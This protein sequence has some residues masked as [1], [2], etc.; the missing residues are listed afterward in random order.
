MSSWIHLWLARESTMLSLTHIVGQLS[1]L[2]L[3]L[4]KCCLHVIEFLVIN[5]CLAHDCSKHLLDILCWVV[6]RLSWSLK[7]S[8]PQVGWLIRCCRCILTTLRVAPLKSWMLALILIV[9]L[10]R[11][12]PSCIHVIGLL[13]SRWL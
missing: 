9:L 11:P 5:G 10:L 7:L 13:C 12:S 1:H 8:L 2:D 6:G 4:R 3:Q